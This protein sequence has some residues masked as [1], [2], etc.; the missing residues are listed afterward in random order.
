[1]FDKF[2]QMFPLVKGHKV[3]EKLPSKEPFL[4]ICFSRVF[5]NCR[6]K[7]VLLNRDARL[8]HFVLLTQPWDTLDGGFC[9]GG[10][11]LRNVL[12]IL[13][14]NTKELILF[15]H[16]LVLDDLGRK[17]LLVVLERELIDVHAVI[18]NVRI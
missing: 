10:L 17:S 18:G 7:R 3:F 8:S 11:F 15:H 6:L 9:R 13:I 4:I 2:A 5:Q 12:D 16:C 1:M 14:S